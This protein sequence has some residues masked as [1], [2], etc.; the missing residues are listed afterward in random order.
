MTTI[1]LRLTRL[2]TICTLALCGC[3]T[4]PDPKKEAKSAGDEYVWV[5]PIGSNIRVKVKKGQTVAPGDSRAVTIDP[6][7][8]N[9]AKFKGSIS[10]PSH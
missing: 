4:P 2:A 6:E 1:P 8:L 9:K 3:A 7:E 10:D 5:T